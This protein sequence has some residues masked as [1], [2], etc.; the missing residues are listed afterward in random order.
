MTTST[1]PM[2]EAARAI[3][4]DVDHR[5][6]LLGYDENGGFWAPAGAHGTVVGR[7]PPTAGDQLAGLWPGCE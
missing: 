3:L 7:C 6:L 1:P 4:L 2:R 5:V